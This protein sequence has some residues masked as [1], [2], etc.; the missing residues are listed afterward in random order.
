MAYHGTMSP[1]PC[2]QQQGNTGVMTLFAR[3]T[4]LYRLPGSARDIK[5]MLIFQDH[6]LYCY[7]RIRS[8]AHVDP[9]N[10]KH[11]CNRKSRRKSAGGEREKW[12]V[13]QG[14]PLI[15]SLI[16]TWKKTEA[17]RKQL[18]SSKPNAMTPTTIDIT[19]VVMSQLPSLTVAD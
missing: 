14:F 10:C 4:I 8:R 15:P 9:A 16:Y 5:E 12:G 19:H 2:T 18:Y 11:K 7:Y 13:S 3:K 17:E 1:M 6:L